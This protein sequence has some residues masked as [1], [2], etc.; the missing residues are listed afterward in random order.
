MYTTRE[1]RGTLI[2]F[3]GIQCSGK[4]TQSKILK[5]NLKEQGLKVKRLS[6][7]NYKTEIGKLIKL[8]H[9][10]SREK[11]LLLS[12]NR[13]EKVPRIINYL[14]QGIHVILDSYAYSS[15][16]ELKTTLG[17]DINICK[18]P[19]FGLPNPDWI[20][21]LNLSSELAI[22]RGSQQSPQHHYNLMITYADIQESNWTILNANQNIDVLSEIIQNH[23]MKFIN[24]PKSKDVPLTLFQ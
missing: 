22:L 6:F 13:W 23:A 7:P 2:V 12:A 10:Q 20:I 3:E 16:V 19:D 21:Q 24:K 4:T 9:H 5:Y 11:Q 18:A 15:V 14:K 8:H 1:Q 17:L